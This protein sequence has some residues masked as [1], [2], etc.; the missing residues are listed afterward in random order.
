VLY[1][2][3]L[4]RRI[5]VTDGNFKA[6]H[7][8]MRRPELDVV[9]TDGEGYFVEDAPY[10]KH[11]KE[12]QD[13]KQVGIEILITGLFILTTYFQINNC[14]KHNAVNE[15]RTGREHLDCTGVGACACARHG[16]FVPH[17][18]VDFQKGER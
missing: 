14:N 2:Y 7:M 13:I 9:L 10:Q 3:W 16:C 8:K 15:S 18:V 17:S 11:L 4:R 5:L 1:S 12:F 6:D